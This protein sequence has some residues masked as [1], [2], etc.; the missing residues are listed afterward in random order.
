MLIVTIALIWIGVRIGMPGWYYVLLGTYAIGMV[1]KVMHN[2]E[3]K[4]E[5]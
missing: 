2:I 1:C 4:G 3:K 5:L